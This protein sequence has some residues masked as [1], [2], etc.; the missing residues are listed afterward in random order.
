M[1]TEFDLE[2]SIRTPSH[3]RKVFNPKL[4]KKTVD[5]LVRWLSTPRAKVLKIKALAGCGNSGVPMISA[6]SYAT[7]L[8]IITVRKKS[9]TEHVYHSGYDVTGFNEGGSYLIVDD[10]I[11]SGATVTRIIESISLMNPS[12]S[13]CAIMLYS[14]EYPPTYFDPKGVNPKL[15][16]SEHLEKCDPPAK[17]TTK[18]TP[19]KKTVKKGKQN[20]ARRR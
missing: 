13:P 6:V 14:Q 17:P 18:K 1:N 5:R 9:E 3:T 15:F 19:P 20:A 2:Y 8:P 16:Y 12:L 4:F 10:L 11:D 7:G